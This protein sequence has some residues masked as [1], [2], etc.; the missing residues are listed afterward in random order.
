MF[1]R[2]VCES[3]VLKKIF[4]GEKYPLGATCYK[5]IYFVCYVVVAQEYQVFDGAIWGYGVSSCCVGTR[6]VVAVR[7]Y[8]VLGVSRGYCILGLLRGVVWWM[9]E[10]MAGANMAG[11][12]T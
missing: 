4:V 9:A 10:I 6:Y 3:L 8:Y 12:Q 1:P 5:E 2:H 11:K 7:G